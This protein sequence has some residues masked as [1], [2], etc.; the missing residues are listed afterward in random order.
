MPGIPAL[1]RLR[2]EDFKEFE[3]SLKYTVRLCLKNNKYMQLNE[4]TLH[5]VLNV[6]ILIIFYASQP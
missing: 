3:E 5:Y 6:C 4:C 1:D 2:Q